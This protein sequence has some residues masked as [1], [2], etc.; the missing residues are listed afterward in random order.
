MNPIVEGVYARLPVWAQNAALSA[1]GWRYRSHRL[2]GRFEEE[3]RGFREREAWPVE[4]MHDYLTR[5]LRRTLIHAF[6]ETEYY[7]AS[8]LPLGIEEGDLARFELSDLPRLPMT[9]KDDFRGSPDA[10][11]ARGAERQGKLQTVHSSGS[12]GTPVRVH[13]DDQAW[14]RMVAAREARSFRWANGTITG[15]RAMI[16]GRAITGAN[17]KPP[18]YRYNRAEEQVYFTAYQ[19]RPSSVADYVEGFRRYKPRLFTGYAHS[20]YFLAQLMLDQGYSLGYKPDAIVLSSEKLTPEMKAVIQKA[21]G[22]RAYE[23]YGSVENVVLATECEKGSLHLHPDF[24]WAEIV[25]EDGAPVP[26]GETGRIVAT[27][28]SNGAQ[29][30]VRYVIGDVGGFSTEL[31]SCGRDHLPTMLPIEGRLEDVLYGPDGRR[32]VRFHSLFLGLPG[33]V[34]AQVIQEQPNS[35][36]VKVVA[37]SDLGDELPAAIGARLRKVAGDVSVRVVRVASI[38]RTRR[39]KFRAVVSLLSPEVKESLRRAGQARM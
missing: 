2:G 18:Y 22:V 13:W 21:F 19:I 29:P 14:Q 4:R 17:P 34:E 12:T 28:F 32:L 11:V 10:F 31:C 20:Y 1:W 5:R 3:V 39:G 27:G 25:D 9:P 36:Q 8:W 23:E 30:L 15:S 26:A 37:T 7:R 6:R 35:F 16:G 24:G 33:V 38:P